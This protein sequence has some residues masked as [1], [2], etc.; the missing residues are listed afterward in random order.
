MTTKQLNI[1]LD[2]RLDRRLEALAARTG[3]TKTFYATEAI[4]GFLE[5]WED[6]FLAKDA[7][8]EFRASGDDA[9]DVDSLDFERLGE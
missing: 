5:D 7:L 1:R 9:I 6:Y 4:A 3:R 8:E 2:A